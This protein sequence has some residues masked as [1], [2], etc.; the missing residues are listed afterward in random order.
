MA[1]IALKGN[2]ISTI[3]ELPRKGT[4]APDFSLTKNDLSDLRLADFA[5]KVKILNIVPSLDT[6]VCAASARAF[7]KAADSLGGVAILTISRDLPFAQKRFCEAEGIKSVVTLSELR[8]RN[9]GIAYGV[10]IVNGP[11]AGLLS[12][13]VVVLDGSN[14]V[15]Y[16]QQV[17]EI[18]QEPDYASALAAAKNAR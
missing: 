5:G 11:M 13:A 2:P 18:T 9:F 4:T 3:G 15:V 12:R 14:K 16:T 17:P 8:D 7:N 10:E 6:G 1:T